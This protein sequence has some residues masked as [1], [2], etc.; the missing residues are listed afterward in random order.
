MLKY[1]EPAEARKPSAKHQWRIFV[2]KGKDT[3]D[4]IHIYARSCWLM[5][6]DEKVCDYWIQHPSASTQHA[7][8]QFRHVQKTD[9]FGERKGEVKPYLIDLESANGTR[10]NGKKVA[11]STYVE[12]LDGDVLAFGESERE[13]VLMLPP[14]A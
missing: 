10:L 6:R 13:Y 14:T 4:T 8:V 9:E 11:A 12:L 1:H 5:G 2:F 7:V 3:I